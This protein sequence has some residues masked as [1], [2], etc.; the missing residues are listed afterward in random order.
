MTGFVLWFTGL[1]GAGKS[2]LALKVGEEV[3]ARGIHVEHLDGDA[4][5]EHISVGLGFSRADRDENIRRIAFVAAIAARCGACSIVSA[6]SPY[7]DARQEARASMSEPFVEVY[8]N[9]PLDVL[10]QRDPKGLYKRAFAGQLRNFTG[11]DDPYEPPDAAEI[12]IRTNVF[13]VG[14]SAAMVV[15]Y[16]ELA[17]LL[18]KVST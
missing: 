3:R 8:L 2:T 11:V 4:I 14:A 10:K 6:I 17:Q 9:C 12:V 5:R 13:S 1:S 18:P 16:L 15:A 7:K